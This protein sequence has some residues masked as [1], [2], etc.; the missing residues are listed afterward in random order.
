MV[1]QGWG[2]GGG[3]V[4]VSLGNVE[5]P[6]T[7]SWGSFSLFLSKLVHRGTATDSLDEQGLS[8]TPTASAHRAEALEGAVPQRFR[9]MYAR[10]N[11]GHPSREAGLVKASMF[12]QGHTHILM[13]GYSHSMVPGGLDVMS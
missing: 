3:F 11:M 9:P 2:D 6:R 10:A 5:V 13:E 7:T 1:P 4:G 12:A 8:I